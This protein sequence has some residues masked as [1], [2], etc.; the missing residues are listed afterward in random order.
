MTLKNVIQPDHAPINK[1]ELS[2]LGLPKI[3]FTKVSGMEQEVK[4][5]TL[6]DF[7]VA[8]GGESDPFEIT[9]EIPLHHEAEIQALE[10]WHNEGKDP[11]QLTYKKPGTMTYKRASG[12]VARAYSLLGMWPPKLKYPDTDMADA[13]TPAVLEVTFS[14]DDKDQL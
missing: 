6:P 11:V 9:A 3:I 13:E 7:T 5:T 10:D 2:V 8:S 4:K 1:Y 12:A 14:I